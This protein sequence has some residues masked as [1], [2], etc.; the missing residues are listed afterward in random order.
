MS[1]KHLY[2]TG[3]ALVIAAALPFIRGEQDERLRLAPAK[4]TQGEGFGYAV[5]MDGGW[6]VVSSRFTRAAYLFEQSEAGWRE[7]AKL[8]GVNA[9]ADAQSAKSFGQALSLRGNWLAAGAPES[10]RG[11]DK[12]AGLVELFELREG[13]WMLNE[14]F[15][16]PEA[17]AGDKFGFALQVDGERFVAGAPGRNASAGAAWV[18]E[19]GETGWTAFPLNDPSPVPSARFG[20]SVALLGDFAFVGAP[21]LLNK[22]VNTG[23]IHV[24]RRL[25]DLGWQWVQTLPGSEKLQGLGESLSLREHTLAAGAFDLAVVY[26]RREQVW[27]EAARIASPDAGAA[28]RFACSIGLSPNERYLLAGSSGKGYLFARSGNSWLLAGAFGDEATDFATANALSDAYFVLN[29]PYEGETYT[30]GA[31]YLYEIAPLAGQSAR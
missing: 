1:R 12:A 29:S 28:M 5:S 2:L 8:A 7:T 16:A 4:F 26:E 19:R 31:A 15:R 17:A 30:N 20:Q 9:K 23:A 11:A 13:Q 18:F 24:F 6:I 14:V 22:R 27:I 21:G 10:F 25:P 3:L